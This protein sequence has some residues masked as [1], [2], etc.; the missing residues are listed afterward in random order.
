MPGAVIVGGDSHT[1]T[2][3]ALG[4]FGTGLGSTDIAACP[5]LRRVLAGRC[6][7]RSGSSSRGERRGFVTGKDLILAVI[8]EIGVAGAHG[9]GA[10]VRRR[11]RRSLSIDE[12]LAVANMA[13][14]AG[15]ETGLF[16]ADD[17]DAAVPRRPDRAPVGRRS[18]RTPTREVA[19][20]RPD[21]PRRAAA[22]R[23]RCR[24]RPG[25]VV[26]LDRGRRAADRPG[27]HRQLRERDDH[28]PAP[29]G[30]GAAR[31]QR[32]PRLPRDHRARHRRRS[33][34]RRSRRAC[35]TRSSRRARWSRPPRAAPA[36]AAAWG[37]SPRA[38]RA[39][40]TTNRNFRGRMGSRESEVLPG[41]RLGRRRSRRGGRDRASRRGDRGVPA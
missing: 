26:P 12:R 9:H 24:T 11:R 1:C 16:P 20:E 18:G 3:G 23:R 32:A 36:S 33:T 15:A 31:P 27:V 17:D 29:G 13:V 25:N 41:E 28:R 39:I 10:R 19:R 5:G 30:R 6:P 38:R 37:S 40:T 4:A 34:G 8:A 35:S 2:Y 22:A 14:E 7:A 21:R